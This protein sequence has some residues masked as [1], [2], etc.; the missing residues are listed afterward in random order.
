MCV[1]VCV[2]PMLIANNYIV[3]VQLVSC[4][5]ILEWTEELKVFCFCTS[6]A[7]IRCF[8]VFIAH[9]HWFVLYSCLSVT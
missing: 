9:I 6:I 4:H 2:C 3:P 8:R 1:C 5:V 7:V